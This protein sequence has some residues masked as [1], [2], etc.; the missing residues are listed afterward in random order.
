MQRRSPFCFV[1]HNRLSHT[2]CST[3]RVGNGQHTA[4]ATGR[5]SMQHTAPRAI[6]S[7]VAVTC[8]LCCTVLC[9]RVLPAINHS[10]T[11]SSHY[12]SPVAC[13]FVK[14][15]Q[16]RTLPHLASQALWHTCTPA[17][18]SRHSSTSSNQFAHLHV[19][20][21]QPPQQQTSVRPRLQPAANVG[22]TSNLGEAACTCAVQSLCRADPRSKPFTAEQQAGWDKPAVCL[23]PI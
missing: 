1:A 11:S 18:S 20:N 21:Q 5:C 6:S 14:V 23:R 7:P 17:I 9:Q 16:L 12:M 4:T 10:S 22:Q 15:I 2:T 19:R 8:T 13:V 3:P